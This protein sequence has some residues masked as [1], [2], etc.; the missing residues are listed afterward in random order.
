MLGNYADAGVTS[1]LILI[2]GIGIVSEILKKPDEKSRKKQMQQWCMVI[3]GLFVCSFLFALGS[4]QVQEY[5]AVLEEKLQ[6]QTMRGNII[7]T[8]L[9]MFESLLVGG[10]LI[11]GTIWVYQENLSEKLFAAVLAMLIGLITQTFLCDI[12][13]FSASLLTGAPREEFHGIAKYVNIVVWVLLVYQIFRHLM[14]E[15]IQKMIES[16]AEQMHQFVQVPMMSYVAYL[17][18][19]AVMTTFG[20]E[21]ISE[22]STTGFIAF[23]VMLALILL[24][25][26]MYSSIFKALTLSV[27]S[28]KVKAELDVASKIQLSAVPTEFP[29]REEF[30]VYAE[31]YPAKEVGGDFYDFFFIDEERIAILIADVSGKGVPAALF[32]MSGRAILK[33]QLLSGVEPAEAL[34]RANNQLEENNKEGMFITSFIGI[35][36]IKTGLFQYANAGHN[37]PYI[38]HENGQVDA[39]EMRAGFVL[40]G[41]RDIRYRTKEM[42]LQ[43][44][45]KIVLYTDGVT[46]AVNE[47]LEL[48][49]EKRLC[50]VLAQCGE[51]HSDGVVKKI[52]A[53]VEAFAGEA[54]QADDITLLVLEMKS[55]EENYGRVI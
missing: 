3:V 40:A 24:Y 6:T 45:D 21:I 9:N 44:G 17:M 25:L 36:N 13:Y 2:L 32:M 34:R 50:E 52:V 37:Q 7:Y 15:K 1:C 48:Y 51:E 10:A 43:K 23:I 11:L 5:V 27:A 54:E 18:L 26:L 33:N 46:E 20:I 4:E 39:I 28:M 49:S 19:H 29:N 55:L 47:A 14:A 22:D 8:L 42:Y 38:C 41:M 31:M 35:V 53:S 16:S 30:G 12:T